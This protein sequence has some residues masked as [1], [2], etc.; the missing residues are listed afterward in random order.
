MIITIPLG[1]IGKRFKNSKYGNTP[2]ALIKVKGLCILYYLLDNLNSE[3]IKNKIDFIYI[4]YNK[5][6]LD[7]Y[8]ESR[9]SERYPE[10]KFKFMVLEKNTRGAAETIYISLSDLDS[11]R[12]EDQPILCLDSDNFYFDIDIISKWGGEN[13]VFTFEDRRPY[14]IFSYITTTIGDSHS[15]IVRSIVEKNKISDM[16]CCGAY[17]FDS[18]KELKNGCKYIISNNIKQKSEFY[19]SGVIKHM[20]DNLK[21]QFKSINVPNKNYFS[22]GTPLQVE[23][24]THTFLFDLDGTLV[25][26]DHIY[27]DV[28]KDLLC[29][30]CENLSVDEDFFNSFIRGQSDMNFLK[31]LIP[32]IT[33]EDINNISSSKDDKFISKLS[34]MDRNDI[35]ISGV[36]PDFFDKI[37][38][39]RIAVV[40]SC[41]KKSAKYILEKTGLDDYVELLIASEDCKNH[42]PHPEPYLK[43]IEQLKATRSKTL[44]F[45]DSV[46]GFLSA[47]N[48]GRIKRVCI[49]TT[50]KSSDE[51]KLLENEFKFKKYSELDTHSIFE[52]NN[53]DQKQNSSKS[54]PEYYTRLIKE[55]INNLPVKNVVF[56]NENLKT[57]YICDINSYKLI[58][59]DNEYENIVLKISN[60]DNEL[61]K[62]AVQLNMYKNESYFYEHI[63][64]VISNSNNII[65]IPKN[66]GT[67]IND[68]KD[69][70]LLENLNK[71][72]GTF[73]LD[74]NK[75]ISLLLRVV[76]DLYKM[77]SKFYFE[78]EDSVIDCMKPLLTVNKI[79]YYSELIVKRF[80][81]FISKNSQFISESNKFILM[82]IYTNF[83]KI[84]NLVSEYPLSFCHGDLKSP[85]IFY[86]NDTE[87][88]YL[89]WQYIHLNKGVSDIIFLLVESIKFNEITANIVEKYYYKMI[90]EYR[91]DYS[92]TEYLKEFKLCLCIFPFFVCVWF[93][94]EDSEKLLDKVF[95]LRFMKNLLMYYDYYLSEDFFVEL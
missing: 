69:G 60:L 91:K 55:K 10:Y 50:S 61:S 54:S 67:I 73:N 76:K 27:V 18:W 92:Y 70:I 26:T 87:P 63:S 5:E 19:T 59:T 68:D 62:T 36:F 14:P 86:R 64:P 77:H 44:I 25:D 28:W 74:L 23:Q 39:S 9:L 51:I 21:K 7:Y 38:N 90:S 89:D 56:N 78:S 80:D 72:P 3:S 83:K 17:G 4:P 94:S 85:N 37:K 42:K 16:A 79:N 43:A 8:L 2:K 1:G 66:Y 41:N 35:L 46:S 24:Y 12:I 31:F 15:Q 82:S 6:Y 22:L 40:T 81:K 49:I 29:G 65:K 34:K 84:T 53:N 88:H 95:P 75:N 47:K 52:H 71:Y 11:K 58:Y 48:V 30:Y 45:E 32:E 93:N 13:T 57:G 33:Q 20:I